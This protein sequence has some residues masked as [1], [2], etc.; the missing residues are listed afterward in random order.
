ML[1]LGAGSG[2]GAPVAAARGSIR[3][4]VESAVREALLTGRFVPGRAVTLR[5]LAS[6]LGVS[7]M[8]V[9]EAVRSLSAGHALEVRPNGRIQVPTMTEERLAE[10]LK[11]RL[12]LEP[13]LA[14]MAASYPADLDADALA[15]LDDRV[16]ESLI[17]GDAETY[18]RYNHAFHFHIYRA[19]RSEVLLPLVENLWLQFAPFMRTVY[20]RVGTAALDDHHKEA[21]QAVRDRDA[22]ALRS[23][24]AADIRCGME[25]LD[26]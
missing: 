19:S 2:P 25:L 24:V 23:A 1:E 3:D 17:G 16:D 15:A 4:R 22:G 11:A 21:V 10:I 12:L 26:R 18:M 13:E 14:E 20:G 9:R 5:G 6:E 8:P 7:P